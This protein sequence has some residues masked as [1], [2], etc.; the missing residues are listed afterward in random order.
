MKV[1]LYQFDRNDMI[2]KLL[3]KNNNL[4]IM[5]L[6]MPL[7]MQ[8]SHDFSYSDVTMKQI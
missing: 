6:F 4:Y 3:T 8:R 7:V 2:V 5:S 1:L